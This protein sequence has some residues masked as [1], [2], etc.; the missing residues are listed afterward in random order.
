M[1]GFIRALGIIHHSCDFSPHLRVSLFAPGLSHAHPWSLSSV[2]KELPC[3][4]SNGLLLRFVGCLVQNL[5]LRLS[6]LLEVFIPF[7]FCWQIGQCV[8]R[9]IQPSCPL[10]SFKLSLIGLAADNW[11]SH[12]LF[13]EP[14]PGAHITS[15][16]FFSARLFFSCPSD[17]CCSHVTCISELTAMYQ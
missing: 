2:T 17:A 1:A 4:T 3:V 14:M 5:K 6:A 10:V 7:F 11:D 16:P 15:L 13:L 12:H 8:H 9:M